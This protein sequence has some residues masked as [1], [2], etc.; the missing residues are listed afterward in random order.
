[1]KSFLLLFSICI[2]TFFS[3]LK[4][5]ACKCISKLDFTSSEIA[6]Y[7]YIALVKIVNTSPMDTTAGLRN[8]RPWFFNAQIE[9][10][11]RFK[12]DPIINLEVLG[13]KKEFGYISSCN[14][15]IDTGEEWLIFG[16]LKDDGRIQINSCSRT[17]VYNSNSI[18]DFQMRD[19]RKILDIL[20]EIERP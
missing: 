17:I 13:G 10:I 20:R 3:P 5:F 19:S 6:E 12:G 9:E 11:Q 18:L 7:D 8:I 14:L 4:C 2:L 15:G 16:E 1:M